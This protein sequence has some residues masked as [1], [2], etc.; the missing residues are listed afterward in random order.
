MAFPNLASV[1]KI[2][3]EPAI[4]KSEHGVQPVRHSP[5]EEF[6]RSLDR[7]RWDDLKLF[8]EVAR[9]GSFRAA[10]KSEKLSVNTV[11]NRIE[12]LENALETSL[13]ER[14]VNGI[15][16][17]PAG[18]GLHPVVLKMH[19][20]ASE[21]L[22][23]VRGHRLISPGE[24]RIGASEALGSGWLTPRLLELQE[25]MPDLTVTLLCDYD[26]QS[27]RSDQVDVGILWHRPTNP[28][29]I[30]ARLATVHF[31]AF[32]S[33]DYIAANGA[34]ETMDDLLAH[35]Y[36]EQVAPGVKSSLLDQMVG[37]ERPP[38]FL[39]L[40]TNS[41]LA[42]FWAVATG[43]GIAWMPTYSLAVTRSLVP[44]DLPFQLKF[45]LFYYFRPE[46]ADSLPV[47]TTI[48]WLKEIFDPGQYPFFRSEFVHPREFAG[49]SARREGKV[50][51]L[52][53]PLLGD[54]LAKP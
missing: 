4:R 26:V 22:G 44:I 11:R 5:T 52:F 34:P 29:L 23:Q 51:R 10:A 6:G 37:T 8:V 21:G 25:Q 53:E 19:S 48:D 45:D 50:V 16:L 2:M 46:A 15:I 20:R 49:P 14:S 40:R 13:F 12:R 42:L 43:A 32:A 36:I 33:R 39:P 17:T 47:R 18:A 24:I 9:A 30:V 38:G 54:V 3:Q 1:G 28:D 35:R 27:E 31:M 7:A 41:S